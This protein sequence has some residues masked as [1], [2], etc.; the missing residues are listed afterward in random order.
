MLMAV[1]YRI[2][3]NKQQASLI[4]K[5]IGCS[6]LIYNLMLHDFYENDLIKTPAKYKN[7]YPFL[8]EV[9]S[10]ALA[11]SQM[12]LKK[13]FRNYKNNKEHFDKPKFKKKSHSKLT[14]TTNNQKGTIRIE[15]NNLILPK[16]KSGIKIVLHRLIDGVIK[17]VTKYL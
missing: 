13:A 4:H 7:E 9:D 3:P 12:N 11:N 15:N 2:Y 14:Y 10:L 5:T 17:S 6:R 1:K 8:K 16:F